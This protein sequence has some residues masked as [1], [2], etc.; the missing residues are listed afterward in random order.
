MLVE[1]EGGA[2][3]GRLEVAT[4][5]GTAAGA[6]V[7]FVFGNMAVY[8]AVA[9]TGAALIDLIFA[10]KSAAETLVPT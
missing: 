10:R 1:D 7:G 3:K 2:G 5:A 8:G 4:G 9:D 6:A